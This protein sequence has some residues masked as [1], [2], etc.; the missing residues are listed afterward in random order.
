MTSS[1]RIITPTSGGNA[2]LQAMSVQ[3]I[4]SEARAN[5]VDGS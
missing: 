1:T 3:A 5:M 4:A 2:K